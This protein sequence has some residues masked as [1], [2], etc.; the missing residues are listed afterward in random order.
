M[1]YSVLLSLSINLRNSPL[2]R[3]DARVQ[4]YGVWDARRN[5]GGRSPVFVEDVVY[6]FVLT[7]IR[8]RLVHRWTARGR[9]EVTFRVVSVIEP[10]AVVVVLRSN[11]AAARK[12]Q[13]TNTHCYRATPCYSA[14]YMLW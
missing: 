3:D 7:R 1:M 5:L 13:Y 11:G 6:G 4:R 9:D 14:V 2:A 8:V 12:L 10:Q